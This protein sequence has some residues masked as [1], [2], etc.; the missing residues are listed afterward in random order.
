MPT[1]KF[2]ERK[3]KLFGESNHVATTPKHSTARRPVIREHDEDSDLGPMSPLEFS[4]SPSNFNRRHGILNEATS[5]RRESFENV[6]NDMSLAQ[7]YSLKKLTVNLGSRA[8]CSDDDDLPKNNVTTDIDSEDG[9]APLCDSMEKMVTNPP[10]PIT[11]ACVLGD[12]ENYAKQMKTPNESTTASADQM[13]R[14]QSFR[15]TLLLDAETTPNEAEPTAQP[16]KPPASVDRPKAKTS[17]VFSEP[18]IPTKSFYGSSATTNNALFDRFNSSI[19]ASSEKK[20]PIMSII[21]K[22][23]KQSSTHRKPQPNKRP[24]WTGPSLWRN[25]GIHKPMR[26]KRRPKPIK[27][28][29]SAHKTS[30]ATT[31]SST[32]VDSIDNHYQRSAKKS[33]HRSTPNTNKRP[34]SILKDQNSPQVP[35]RA[36][37]STSDADSEYEDDDDDENDPL[38]KDIGILRGTTKDAENDEPE[39]V[40]NRKFFKSNANATT[41]KYQIMSGLSATLKRGNDFKLELPAKRVRRSRGM[42]FFRFSLLIQ[43]YVN[44][45][46]ISVSHKHISNI[47]ANL[48][49]PKKSNGFMNSTNDNNIGNPNN[50]PVNPI[51]PSQMSQIQMNAPPFDAMPPT[52]AT[53]VDAPTSNENVYRQMIPYNTTDPSKISQQESILELLISNNICN[54]ETF[55]IFIAEP[56]LHKDKAS[57]ILD[58]LYC[59]SKLLPEDEGDVV[60]ICEWQPDAGDMAIE[61]TSPVQAQTVGAISMTDIDQTAS[62]P[63]SPG[64]QISTMASTLALGEF[65]IIP[66]NFQHFIYRFSSPQIAY[67]SKRQRQ[68]QKTHRYFQYF[69]RISMS[70]NRFAIC[71]LT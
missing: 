57:A 13:F 55:K 46:L 70:R 34:Q 63:M 69:V 53:R 52:S 66:F 62:V 14:G 15:K 23:K 29:K 12:E 64:T 7:K 19:T 35:V 30:D 16:S 18:T 58:E 27:H 9:V 4:S 6:L 48:Q 39:I 36:T 21:S 67:Q 28:S 71:T 17:L 38:L 10:T 45:I 54:D 33:S 25:G 11:T 31:A 50:E 24:K 2:E 5:M 65:P 59:V 40:T 42:N 22:F 26:I 8:S 60:S 20:L 37:G 43:F 3:K 68:L 41:K 56:D 47:I 49:S 51:Q 61:Y 32:S 1:P 44:G